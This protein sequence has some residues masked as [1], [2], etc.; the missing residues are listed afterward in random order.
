MPF[1]VTSRL[2]GPGEHALADAEG[3]AWPGVAGVGLGLATAN[4]PLVVP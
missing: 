3:L 4:S 2:F 1:A